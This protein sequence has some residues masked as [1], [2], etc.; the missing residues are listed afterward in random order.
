MVLIAFLVMLNSCMTSKLGKSGQK[1]IAGRTY[2]IVGASSGFGRGVAEQLGKYK[3]N[4]VVAA[5]RSDLLQEVVNNIR[6]AGGTALAVTM[7]ISKPEDVERLLDTAVKH[8]G[9]IDVWINMAG[10]GAIS[11]FWDI[12]VQDQARIVDINLK[13]FVYGS[14]AAIRQFRKQGYGT[15]IN[16]GSVESESPLA[17][18]ATYAATKAGVLNLSMALNQELRLNGYRDI[19]VVNVE[20]WA[21]DT[22]FWGHAVNYS[23]GTPRMAAMDGPEKVVNAVI[24]SSLRP[25]AEVPVGFKAQATWFFHRL[26]PRFTEKLSAGIIHKY[27]IKDAPPAPP[28]KGSA[29]APMESGRGVDDGVRQRM[30]KEKKQK[31]D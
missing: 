3:V 28:T 4:V 21:T 29:Y 8:Y 15:L 20:P 13:G 19:K 18:H 6:A 31:K 2:V 24:R 9:N 14:H 27:Q 30:E 25:K 22:P 26:F 7:D 23:G 17:Y 11:P 1:E 5:R 16:M 12:P 10:V